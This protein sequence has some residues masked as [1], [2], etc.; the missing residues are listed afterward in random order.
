MVV[1][2]TADNNST[3]TRQSQ[4]PAA[5]TGVDDLLP[6]RLMVLG[7][8]HRDGTIYGSELYPVAEDCGIRVETVRSCMRRLMSDG[9]F[10][11][12]GEGRDAIFSATDAGLS[13]L[14]IT[15]QR[16]LLAFAQDSA[17]RGWD[18]RWRLVTFAIPES[19]RAERDQFRD[20][21]ITLGGASLQ[22]GVYI[23]PHRWEEEIW[24][25]ANRLGIGQHITTASTDDINISG[26]SD[27]KKIVAQLWPLEEVAEQYKKFI[28]TYEHV[29]AELK[30][31]AR[32]GNRI[33]ETD[34]LP[35]ALHIAIRFNECFERDPLL[36]P[37]LLTRPWPG[38][39]ARE[40]LAQ[41]RKL[42]SL[43]REDKS[44]PALFR[45]FDEAISHL[46]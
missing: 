8:A 5:L 27:P 21:L 12:E 23:S 11:R 35:G 33:S 41:C 36:P 7:L 14:G 28:A 44:G 38:R 30:K 34:F 13:L 31:I 37:E 2:K 1:T 26:V 17:G 6:T 3:A 18:R 16:H 10:T 43:A 45:V 25:E 40:L 39:K 9:L 24:A 19:R 4:M 42:G 46:P 22:P 29:P 20:H 32:S 15:E